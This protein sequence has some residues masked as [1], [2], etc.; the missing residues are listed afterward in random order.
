MEDTTRLHQRYSSNLEASEHFGLRKTQ[1]EVKKC[2]GARVKILEI[3]REKHNSK[4]VAVAPFNLNFSVIGEHVHPS[5][6]P[7]NVALPESTAARLT[8]HRIWFSGVRLR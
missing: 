1:R 8:P 7:A 6:F 4:R 3:A 5:E 2:I